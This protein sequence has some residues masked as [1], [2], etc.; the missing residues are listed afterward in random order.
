MISGNITQRGG[1]SGGLTAGVGG[2]SDYTELEN[3]PLINNVELIGNKSAHDLNLASVQDVS[4]LSSDVALMGQKLPKN[5]STDEQNTGIK[6][7]DGKYIYQRTFELVSP[8]QNNNYLMNN[9]ASVISYNGFIKRT[10]TNTSYVIPY[11][12]T[13]DHASVYVREGNAELYLT[14]WF[15]NYID[16]GY[17]TI[18]Y[19]KIEV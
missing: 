2:T 11:S 8:L 12:D 19:T 13:G 5:Y 18:F 4:D 3:K 16:I 17:V 10:Y 7:I 9:V 6:W 14:D 1:L 15:K